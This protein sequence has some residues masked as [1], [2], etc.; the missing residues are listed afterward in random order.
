MEPEQE[1]DSGLEPESPK[2][3]PTQNVLT[4]SPVKS[5]PKKKQ[6]SEAQKAGLA[7]A[8]EKARQTK[9]AKT[10]AKKEDAEQLRVAMESLKKQQ[11]TTPKPADTKMD[12]SS[13]EEES[14]VKVREHKKKGKRHRKKSRYS[15]SSESEED[16]K[17]AAERAKEHLGLAR[18]AYDM[19]IARVKNDLVYK[20][21]FPYLG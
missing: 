10:A 11:E 8:R 3:E 12:E 7:K 19:N 18:A 20:S 4:N 16:P 15:S 2:A 9:L 17:N 13:A 1:Y 21:L 6:L 5:P 14:P